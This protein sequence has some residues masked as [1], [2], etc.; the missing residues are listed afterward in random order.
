MN[1]AWAKVLN[2]VRKIRKRLGCSHSAALF[3]GH[4]DS[5]WPLLPSLHRRV[6]GLRV[7]ENLYYGFLMRG[8]RHL[9]RLNSSWMILTEMQHHGIPTRLLDWTEVFA[10]ALYFALYPKHDKPCIW[11]M[12]PFRLTA[13]SVGERIVFTL[14]LDEIPDYQQ[15]HLQQRQ[16]PYD[17]P[18]AIEA[19]WVHDRLQ[20]QKGWFTVHGNDPRPIDESCKKYV[21]KVELPTEAIP[22]ALEFLD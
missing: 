14:G 9:N 15:A 2:D 1:S 3:R 19:P 13:A 10:V 20:A 7:E 22:G 11:V 5:S 17:L 21:Q 16:W 8:S 18:V 12:N 4:N 6:E